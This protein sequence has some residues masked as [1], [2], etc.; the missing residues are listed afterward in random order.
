MHFSLRGLPGQ[1]IQ[2]EKQR[3]LFLHSALSDKM[4]ILNNA[5]NHLEDFTIHKVKV[6]PIQFVTQ[7]THVS[8]YHGG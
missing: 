5:I 8:R 2:V 1:T 7:F 6:G 3:P 4:T